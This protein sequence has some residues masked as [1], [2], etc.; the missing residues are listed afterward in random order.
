[1]KVDNNVIIHEAEEYINNNLTVKE[2]AA[3]LGISRRTLQIHFNRL[4]SIDKN[5]YDKVRAKRL[6]PTSSQ[7]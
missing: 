3:V 5:L 2:T 6:T 1:M 4:E 7:S